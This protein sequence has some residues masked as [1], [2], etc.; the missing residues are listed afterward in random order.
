M[1]NNQVHDGIV[2][3]KSLNMARDSAQGECRVMVQGKG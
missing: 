2:C 3:E 1:E